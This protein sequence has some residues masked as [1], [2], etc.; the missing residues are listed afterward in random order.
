MDSNVSLVLQSA[1]A[2]CASLQAALP[3]KTN[4]TLHPF[5]FALRLFLTPF[6][7]LSLSDNKIGHVAAAA[8]A[9]GISSSRF[10]TRLELARCHIGDK[11]A[12]VC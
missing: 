10:I 5:H 11:G 7:H 2:A 12:R 6:Q 8:L 9:R 1:V 4:K 3:S